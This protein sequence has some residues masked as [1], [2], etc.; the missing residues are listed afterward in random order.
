M[1]KFIANASLSQID[2]MVEALMTDDWTSWTEYVDDLIEEEIFDADG[3]DYWN[4]DADDDYSLLFNTMRSGATSAINK[5][6]NDME[7]T[8]ARNKS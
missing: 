1:K 6:K 2:D 7:K 8:N 4:G 5:I 3:D